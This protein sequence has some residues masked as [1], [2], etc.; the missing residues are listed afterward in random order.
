MT[1]LQV[2]PNIATSPQD[3]GSLRFETETQLFRDD[4]GNA[5]TL[6]MLAGSRQVQRIRRWVRRNYPRTETE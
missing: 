2:P 3:N 6:D 4:S 1:T 5:W